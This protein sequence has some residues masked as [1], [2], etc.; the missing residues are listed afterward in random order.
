MAALGLRCCVWAFSRCGEQGPLSVVCRL[1]I[2][3]ASLVVEPGFWVRGLQQLCAQA[4]LLWPTGLR[5]RVQL[6]QSAWAL[7]RPGIKPMS[8]ALAGGFFTTEP[9]GK[10][11]FSYF[12]ILHYVMLYITIQ[13]GP[14]FIK[15]ILKTYPC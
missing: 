3:E 15:Y 1:L 7:P 5:A 9:L 11:C 2:A 14:P 4:Q 12:Q 13:H 6:P 8:P 10:L